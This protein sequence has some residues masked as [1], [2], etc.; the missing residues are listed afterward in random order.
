MDVDRDDR[1]FGRRAGAVG[2]CRCDHVLRVNK[3]PDPESMVSKVSDNPCSRDR[4]GLTILIS[5]G[6]SATLDSE[7]YS[8]Y[9]MFG[10]ISIP[11]SRQL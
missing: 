10:W 8:C 5:P 1:L 11:V 6:N 7:C 3:I 2:G 4:R 9:I